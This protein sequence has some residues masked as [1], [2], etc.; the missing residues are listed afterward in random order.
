MYELLIE[1]ADQR[2]ASDHAQQQLSA[3]YDQLSNMNEQDKNLLNFKG[4]YG[5]GQLF[6]LF[7]LCS[8]R[9]ASNLFKISHKMSYSLAETSYSLAELD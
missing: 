7:V 4:W 9:Q 3:K 8:C 1:E 6:I 2:V 5:V